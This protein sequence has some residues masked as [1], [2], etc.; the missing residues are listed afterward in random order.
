M[1]IQQIRNSTLRLSI[2]DKTILTDPVLLP[3]HG[4][5]SFA[6]IEKNPIVDL[7][8]PAQ[9]IIKDIDLV[10]VSH[11]HQDHFDNGAKELLPKEVPMFCQPGDDNAIKDNGFL[12]VS[13]IEK[14]VE[15]EGIHIT[16]TPGKHA[17]NEKWQKI[18]GNV[19]G[20]IFR[21]DNEPTVYWAGDTILYDEI[22]DT[23]T[24]AK[25]DI[26]L[27]HSCGAILDDS[28]PIVMDAKQTIDVCKLAP[29]S[30]VV[31]THLNA[32]DHGTVTRKDLRTYANDNGITKNQLVI[33]ED[34]Q[35][36]TF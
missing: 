16:R 10:I 33:P 32:L 11:L 13:P 17:G 28:G 24:K 35:T 5:E 8:F 19:S 7:P 30:I 22:K 25:P 29:N 18:L 4:I 27:T 23:I 1:K 12:H 26:I 3:K 34:G 31:A 20:F 21:T 2:A 36:L 6:G 14:S 15:W 9:E